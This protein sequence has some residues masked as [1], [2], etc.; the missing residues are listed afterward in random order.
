[1]AET[2][3]LA[4][5]GTTKLFLLLRCQRL[6]HPLTLSRDL[7]FVIKL[8][9]RLQSCTRCCKSEAIAHAY[10]HKP[11][12]SGPQCLFSIMTHSIPSTFNSLGTKVLCLSPSEFHFNF[13]TPQGHL[14]SARSRQTHHKILRCDASKVSRW[15]SAIHKETQMAWDSHYHRFI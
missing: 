9:T 10:P 12:L 5:L 2:C 6:S 13:C 15:E 14:N 4:W 3:D 8:T 1:M 7:P 11:M